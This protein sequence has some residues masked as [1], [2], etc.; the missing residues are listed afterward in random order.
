MRCIVASQIHCD[1]K[2]DE[3]LLAAFYKHHVDQAAA[4]DRHVDAMT[5]GHALPMPQILQVIELAK[6]TVWRLDG[7]CTNMQVTV[8]NGIVLEPVR[9]GQIIGTYAPLVTLPPALFLR[10][11][12]LSELER[13]MTK[14][15]IVFY[16]AFVIATKEQA[17]A[18]TQKFPPQ[19]YKNVKWADVMMPA[20]SMMVT[21]ADFLEGKDMDEDEFTHR[22]QLFALFISLVVRCPDSCACEILYAPEYYDLVTDNVR[23]NCMLHKMNVDLPFVKR[24]DVSV[25]T[26]HFM[27]RVVYAQQDID[28][29]QFLTVPAIN[30][31]SIVEESNNHHPCKFTPPFMRDSST[32]PVLNRLA[33]LMNQREN[34]I[35]TACTELTSSFRSMVKR[36]NHLKP[37]AEYPPEWPCTM[38]PMLVMHMFMLSQL[39][40][41]LDKSDPI[42]ATIVHLLEKYVPVGFATVPWPG[43]NV[44]LYSR[45]CRF[46]PEE[47]FN[48][49]R[50]SMYAVAQQQIG[51]CPDQLLREFDEL[52]ITMH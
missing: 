47:Q 45:L 22:L 28:V 39:V 15:T 14:F 26:S 9:V 52:V 4:F 13:H 21:F 48:K 11:D 5:A 43:L 12:A 32:E 1:M 35:G 3:L 8:N 19:T 38:P 44:E 10:G 18:V 6:H 29:G 2:V 16:T 37:N 20:L 41:K 27:P 46:Y 24:L 33:T 34:N 31:F 7:A 23:P 40:L 25:C 49:L 51:R 50:E 36:L 30:P 17:V 42:V